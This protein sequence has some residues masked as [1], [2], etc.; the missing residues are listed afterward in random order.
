MMM[1]GEKDDLTFVLVHVENCYIIGNDDSLKD[2]VEKI[3]GHGLSVKVVHETKDYLG[4]EILLIRIR[5]R[6]GLVNCL[7]SRK[8]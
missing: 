4:C 2:L 3:K 7:L 1:K 5:Q 6:H 8:C